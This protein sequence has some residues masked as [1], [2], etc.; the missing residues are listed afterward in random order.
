MKKSILRVSVSV[1]ATLFFSLFCCYEGFAQGKVGNWY[2]AAAGTRNP[3]SVGLFEPVQ[4]QPS[5]RSVKNHL[6]LDVNALSSLKVNQPSLLELDL[7][8]ENST[9]KLNLARVNITSEDFTLVTDKGQVG[10]A[11]GLH[12]RGIVNNDPSTIASFSVFDGKVVGFYST[13]E[14]NFN[15]AQIE[16]GS[17][18]YGI[19]GSEE[20]PAL[21]SFDCGALEAPAG[22]TMP[23]MKTTGVGCKVVKIYFECDYKMYQDNGNNVT[24]TANYVAAIFNQI[25]T[26][27]ANENIEVQISQTF[28]WTT[29]DPYANKTSTSTVLDAFRMYRG[30][31]F[32]GN[33]AHLLTTR[34]LG[35]GIAY[36]DVICAKSYAYGVSMI[37]L[38]YNAVPTY[39]W[40]IEVVTHE[41]GH[42]LGS[43]HTQSC[44]WPGGPIDNCYTPEG[45]CA[46]GP[47]P[48]NGGTIMSYCHLTNIG[49]NFNNGF[50]TL[51]GNLIRDR[52]TN[53]SCLV[54]SGT[55]PAGLSTTNITNSTADLSWI[56]TAGATS[57]TVEYK[58]AS[59]STWTPTTATANT[60]ISLSGLQPGASYQ[61]RVSTQCS[62]PS[63]P[64]SFNTL[65]NAACST[66]TNL[67]TT[68][69]T[70]NTATVNW[71]VV[72]NAT[73]Y[74]VDYKLSSASTWTTIIGLTSNS[75]NLTSLAPGSTYDWRV[76]T[77]CSAPAAAVSFTT[78]A[79]P[80]GCQAATGLGV[81]NLTK[82]AA[83]LTWGAVPG[84]QSYS[85]KFHKVGANNWTNYN[86]ISG[87][88]KDV[89]GLTGSSTYEF[90]LTT[91]CSGGNTSDFSILYSFTTPAA[92]EEMLGGE[93][94]ALYPNPAK[95]ILNINVTGWNADD[96]GMGEIY[97]IQGAKL[98]S[99]NVRAGVNNI[100]LDNMADALYM[101][102]IKKDGQN[103]IVQ[104]FIKSSK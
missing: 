11:G 17:G 62:A 29:T 55:A 101:V 99:F 76:G 49:I 31:S 27:Y 34:N 23:Q 104:K 9:V 90:K 12:Y 87:T 52:V 32:N 42:N 47:T 56:A 66:A 41:L 89:T 57:Y 20:L 79:A 103:T 19:Y 24:T 82:T 73:S 7:P 75:A 5:A 40:T 59:S 95:D 1:L 48:T 78:Q 100:S 46:A 92:M 71:D 68:N 25:S 30:T 15:L 72:A 63:A 81:S 16:D 37:Y 91:K 21:G 33:L 98:K 80:S 8:I 3:T 50:G 14:G 86:N 44:T 4:L 97:N 58:I 28:V 94:V 13:S 83:R 22:T 38:T 45:G 18:L 43:P 35:G 61:W 67:I 93:A 88:Y 60:S 70:Q 10:Y 65:F 26:L 51:P 2:K 6:Q 54:G 64:A 69:V 84:A 102:Y 53:A 77:D 96:A 85:V 39:S 74:T 36:V